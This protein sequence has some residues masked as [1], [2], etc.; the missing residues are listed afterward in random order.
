[1]T[2][3]N[4]LRIAGARLMLLVPAFIFVYALQTLIAKAVG[5]PSS[6][7]FALL[8][9]SQSNVMG[10]AFFYSASIFIPILVVSALAAGLSASLYRGLKA[11]EPPAAPRS[12]AA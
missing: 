1:M 7:P 9:Y 11:A 4:F 6:D 2:H 12:P 3:G 5:A 10:F 8:T